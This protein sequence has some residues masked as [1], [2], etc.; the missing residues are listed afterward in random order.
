VVQYSYYRLKEFVKYAFIT[1]TDFDFF[2]GTIATVS[3]VLEFHPEADI[4]V[5]QN[6]KHPQSSSQAAHFQNGE[7]VHFQP[8]S[9]FETGGRFIGAWELKAYAVSD[10]AEGYDVI[11]GI[12]SDCLLCSALHEEIRQCADKGGF[13]GG[14]DFVQNYDHSYGVYG[15]VTPAHNPKYMSTSLFFCAVTKRNRRILRRWAECCN[16]AMFNGT[17]PHPGHGDQGVL[18]AVLC[19]EDALGLVELLDN[20]LWSQHWVY[21]DSDIQY[22]D[23]CFINRAAHNQRQRAFHCGGDEKFWSRKHSARVNGQN[24]KQTLAYAWF[25]AMFWFGR[26]REWPRNLVQH[27][28]PANQHLVAD[29]VNF[30][31]EV[32]QVYPHA[33]SLWGG[34]VNL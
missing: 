9:R 6:D 34:S 21:W 29:L 32:F 26:C 2:P 25:L 17:G 31:P 11:I 3:S 23:G 1:V 18:N 28:T 33:R 14:R 24:S 16:A 8:S 15:M 27:V 12:D 7:R 10:L 22:A 5:I 19:A 30:L 13:M 20:W 4:Y